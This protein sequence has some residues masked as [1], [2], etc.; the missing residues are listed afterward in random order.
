M[1][2]RVGAGALVGATLALSLTACGSPQPPASSTTGA[3]TRG[4][5]QIQNVDGL[6]VLVV[7]N[8][9][10]A[11]SVSGT[12]RLDGHGCW[13]LDAVDGPFVIVWPEGTTWADE[14]HSAVQLASG[15]TVNSGS[16]IT[17]TG[18]YNSKVERSSVSVA[19]DVPCLSG[20]QLTF[21]A[22]GPDAR[23]G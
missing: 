19:S 7:N 2:T 15:T 12:A 6:A 16:K 18:G 13:Q 9:A 20:A 11:H 14:Q 23:L 21:T 17:A 8:G 3:S 1:T 22:L 4:T 10:P 5:E